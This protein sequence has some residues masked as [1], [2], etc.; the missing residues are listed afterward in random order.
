M[1]EK[2]FVVKHGG[3]RQYGCA[4]ERRQW[5]PEET[6]RIMVVSKEI[7]AARKLGTTSRNQTP[8]PRGTQIK[9]SNP[10]VCDGVRFWVKSRF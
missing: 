10:S 4:G 1:A 9:A 7:S 6:P 3:Q 8:S 2:I 5:P